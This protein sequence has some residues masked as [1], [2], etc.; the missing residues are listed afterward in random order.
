MGRFVIAVLDCVLLFRSLER[1][2]NKSSAPVS[3]FMNAAQ[4]EMGR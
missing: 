2:L 3:Q 1:D 4:E